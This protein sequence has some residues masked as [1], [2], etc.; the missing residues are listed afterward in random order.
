MHVWSI[1]DRQACIY[2]I[3]NI[4]IIYGNRIRTWVYPGVKTSAGA[5]AVPFAISLKSHGSKLMLKYVRSVVPWMTIYEVLRVQASGT[6]T[7]TGTVAPMYLCQEPGTR[8]WSWVEGRPP[9][10]WLSV[11][12]WADE[13]GGIGGPALLMLCERREPWWETLADS[14]IGGINTFIS[15]M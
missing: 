15:H 1:F 9:K 6:W 2:K 8:E 5:P 12:P 3:L 4:F 11:F 10:M 13:H 14:S 7:G